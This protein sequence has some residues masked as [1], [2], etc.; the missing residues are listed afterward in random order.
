MSKIRIYIEKE[1]ISKSIIIKEKE[2]LH[3]IKNV[4]RCKNNETIYI[5]DGCGKEYS[6]KLE[7]FKNNVLLSNIE[8]TRSQEPPLYKITLGFPILKEEKI[9]FILQKSTELG[10]WNFIPFISQRSLKVVVKNKLER[11]RKII[12][13]ATRQSDR[14]WIPTLNNVLKFNEILDKKYSIKFFANK[15]GKKIN[16]LLD[17]NY[18]D[19]LVIVGPEGDFSEDEYSLLIKNDFLPLNLSKNILRVETASIFAVGILN[20]FLN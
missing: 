14:L 7:Y 11:W 9:D 20:Y 17:K 2:L 5:F 15:E 13:E 8:L 4:L 1:Y 6:A 10:A 12:I 16:N 19:I 3:K 18:T